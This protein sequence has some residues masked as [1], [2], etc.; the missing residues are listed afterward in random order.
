MFSKRSLVAICFDV[1]AVQ[2]LKCTDHLY[3]DMIPLSFRFLVLLIELPSSSIGAFRI[4]R[5]PARQQVLLLSSSYF[6]NSDTLE[7]LW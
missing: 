5:L 7:K 2:Q 4:K 6:G 1:F 3:D